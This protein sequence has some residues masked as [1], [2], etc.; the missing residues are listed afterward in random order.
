MA[1]RRISTESWTGRLQSAGEPAHRGR[2]AI[3]N[4]AGRT[5]EPR[6]DINGALITFGEARRLKPNDVTSLRLNLS[7]SV[8]SQC[9]KET[10][11]ALEERS[12]FASDDASV[13]C[14]F[15]VARLCLGNYVS[16]SLHCKR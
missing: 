12:H 4:S 5:S 7:H 16:R 10:A 3:A 11:N 9:Q 1:S 14:N 15:G 13:F 2:F 8:R 6:G